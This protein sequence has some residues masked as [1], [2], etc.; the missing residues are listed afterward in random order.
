M[1][2]LLTAF[3]IGMCIFSTYPAHA[4]INIFACEPEWASLAQEIGGNLVDVTS[5]TN[6][7]QDVHYLRAKPSLLEAMRKSDIVFCTG[8]SLE[9][10]WLPILLEK[11]GSPDVQLETVGSIMAFNYVEKLEMESHAHHAGHVHP[12][13]NPHIQL[14]PS[15]IKIIAEILADR[16]FIL[17]PDNAQRYQSQLSTFTQKWDQAQQEWESSK[18]SLKGKQ[19]VAYHN[20]WAYLLKWLDMES[21]ISLESQPGV[22]PTA[23]HLEKVLKAIEKENI[24]A[25]IVAPFENKDAANWLSKKSGIPIIELPFTVGGNEKANDLF[26][27]FDETI[28]LLKENHDD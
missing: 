8:G 4:K 11:T 26:S 28:R 19:V 6:A 16:L 27:L 13:G 21:V 2:K 17:D 10:G 15:N 14:D 5:A 12:E 24:S 18:A 22:S 3:V 23:S 9:I 20:S 7:H 1:R 25:I